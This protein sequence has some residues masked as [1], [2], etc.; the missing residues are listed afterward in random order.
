MSNIKIYG[1]FENVTADGILAQATQVQAHGVFADK[2]MVAF[3]DT[4]ISATAQQR[5]A[6]LQGSGSLQSGTV[7]DIPWG[8]TGT[9]TDDTIALMPTG[10][11]WSESE[12]TFKNFNV[13][14]VGQDADAWKAEYLNADGTPIATKLY[15]CHARSRIYQ[16]AN[17][18]LV[19][20]STNDNEGT[21]LTDEQ[22][23]MLQEH[24]ELLHPLSLAISA[25]PTAV[26]YEGANKSYTTAL[27]VSGKR[28]STSL[29]ASD[30]SDISVKKGNTAVSNLAAAALE[31]GE[32]RFT[33][34]AKYNGK[35]L[36]A[37]VTVRVLGTRYYGALA[38]ATVTA[39]Q[40]KTIA[41][42]GLSTSAAKT[43]NVSSATN[44]YLW[45]CVPQSINIT[46]VESSKIEVPMEAGVEV[47]V[48]DESYK[49]YRS[50]NEIKNGEHEFVV[51]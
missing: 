5:P 38:S 9:P 47:N 32:N 26:K 36:T 16:V 43:V 50:S 29:A 18:D 39:A 8:I 17:G 10:I 7:S 12:K 40:V 14:P 33:A 31:Y 44:F 35:S 25:Q 46:K 23:A 37:S 24:D 6:H 2:R 22:L 21:G 30:L 51:S 11:C 48:D 1:Q 49:C 34:T 3:F 41:D 19:E 27:T 13:T 15:V 45:L 28:G 20:L 4:F 42:A